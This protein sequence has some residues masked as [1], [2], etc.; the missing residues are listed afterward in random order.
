GGGGGGGG[1]GGE[2][3]AVG[4]CRWSDFTAFS[5]HPVKTVA[6]GEGGA[7][8]TNDL[9]AALR[10]ARLRS[11]GIVREAAAFTLSAQASAADGSAHPWY[12]EMAEL[13]F[14]YRV[15]DIQ[16]AL[17]LSQLGKLERFAA[18]RRHLAGLYDAMLPHSVRPIAR[19][20]GVSAAWHLYAV[21]IE[22]AELGVSRDII[23]ARLRDAGIG[24]QVHYVPVPWQP[25]YRQ[26]YSLPPLPGAE[27]YYTRTLSLPLYPKMEDDDVERVVEALVRAIG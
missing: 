11:H 5:F 12:Y 22:F 14:N 3:G 8:T 16:C 20:Q 6:M 7:V 27:R 2:V 26:R 25:Y 21:L 23:M 18:R 17:G 9:E 1:G 24:S 15:C 13:G 19:T 4:D 10:M